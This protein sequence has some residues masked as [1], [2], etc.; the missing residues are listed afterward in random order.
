[1]PSAFR[2]DANRVALVILEM[3]V[4][5]PWRRIR[6]TISDEVVNLGRELVLGRVIGYRW[7]SVTPTP[8]VARVRHQ[9]SVRKQGVGHRNC[10]NACLT[11]H[12]PVEHFDGRKV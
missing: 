10:L 8:R 5:L 4:T 6:I 7:Y 11:A 3:I 12:H 1:M 2:D 9:S